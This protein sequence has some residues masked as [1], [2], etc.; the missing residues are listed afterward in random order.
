MH[1]QTRHLL[2]ILLFCLLAGGAG[3]FT[4][5]VLDRDEARYAQA[6]TQM[7]E[8][9]DFVRIQF[10]EQARNKKPVGIYWL[11][12]LSVTAFS[13]AEARQIWAYRIPSLL[14]A[15]LAALATYLAGIKLVGR[16]AGFAGALVL[17]VS[18]LFAT[19]AGI[20]KTDAALVAS[21]TVMM[22]ALA[23]IRHGGTKLAV[24]V[25]WLAMGSSLLLK[26]PVGPALVV[27][28]LLCLAA[29][30]QKLGWMRPVLQWWGPVLVLAMIV[31]WMWQIQLATDGAF[32]RDALG[33]DFVGKLAS[34]QEGHGLPPGVFSI[35]LPITL[36]PAS[37]FLLPGLLRSWQSRQQVKPGLD[38][39]F[40]LCWA[41]PFFLVLEL[42]PTKLVHYPLPV[43]PAFALICGLG[44]Q[45][46]ASFNWA[47]WVSIA[48]G[49]L[50]PALLL[51]LI[52]YLQQVTEPE[53][54][55]ANGL[56]IASVVL[57][58]VLSIAT[59]FFIVKARI[60]P[61]LATAVLAGLVLHVSFRTLIAPTVPMLTTTSKISNILTQNK[62]HPRFTGQ[63]VL[64]V[65]YAEPS[66]VFALGTDIALAN[67]DSAVFWMITN[68]LKTVIYATKTCKPDDPRHQNA[69]R[70]LDQIQ[71]EH[72]LCPGK[73]I[74]PFYGYNY[75]N[76]QCLTFRIYV[77]Q[78][79]E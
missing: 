64:S 79:C 63:Q 56:V 38:T 46:M 44:W 34:G 47:R 36:F 3:L 68:Q 54:W 71:R 31:P 27:L 4:M 15:M 41:V 72:N 12:A 23:H 69:Q 17:A 45:Y 32:L 28:A 25:F 22:A 48:L 66:L 43:Y 77:L 75:S 37:F 50:T 5:P 33:G 70:F 67:D 42:V 35:L 57:V 18:L 8:T 78:T 65:N 76:S 14:L 10:Q 40:L 39:K 29:W 16:E 24:L 58:L 52:F 61:A 53:I 19:E 74:A 1:T 2:L 60:H 55:R 30:E 13:S 9:G 7:L 26:G 62:L 49:A 11:Q 21:T 20:A 59:G 6:T 73:S 51:G